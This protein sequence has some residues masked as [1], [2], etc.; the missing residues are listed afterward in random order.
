MPKQEWVARRSQLVT[1]YGVG[2]LMAVGSESVMI[3]GIDR[4]PGG[5][6]DLHEPRLERQLGVD[7]FRRPPASDD[8]GD[9]PVVRFPQMVSCPTPGCPVGI[10][11]HRQL[12]NKHDNHCPECRAEL[13]P[14]RFVVACRRGHLDE[15]PYQFWAHRT[16]R[17]PAVEHKLRIDARGASSA[18]RDIEITCSCGQSATM[19]GAF[20]RDALAGSSCR[21]RRPWL[22]DADEDGC[23]E[24]PRVLQRG[25][26][27]VWFP[28]LRS[29]LSIP[30]WSEGVFQLL[31]QHWPV[32]RA[33]PASAVLA[34]IESLYRPEELKH[35]GYTVQD[36]SDTVEER[37]K[38]EAA[39]DAGD[40]P[41]R[42]AEFQALERGRPETGP[43][44][45][46]VCEPSAG[47]TTFV[48][49]Y[50]ARVMLVKRL[51][52]VRVLE[53]F[54]RVLPPSP[55]DPPEF[56]AALSIEP[57]HWLPAI[58]VSGEGIFLQLDEERLRAWEA[59]GEVTARVKPLADR[60]R[61]RFI[62][63]G[64]QPDRDISPRFVL[65]HT[66]AHSLIGQWA[67]DS[68]YPAASL[69]ERLFVDEDHAG[70]LIYTAT[71]DSAGSLGGVIQQG[72]AERLEGS[73]REAVERAGWCSSDPLCAESEASGVD[74]LNLAA[75]HACV[76]LP[77]VS[78][79]EMNVL[80][81]RGLLIGL[82]Q[83]PGLAFFEPI[84]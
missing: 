75:C 67:L 2:S 61:E 29:A 7:G 30:P 82:P 12:T 63:R 20:N 54:T 50:F 56:H 1:T 4:W 66:L 49:Q 34:T 10:E 53:S 17:D 74:S 69:R 68:G 33:V 79:E 27:N 37:R 81:D 55:A 59:R 19:E 51:L 45:E 84:A 35:A 73:L 62:A 52:E 18:L 24:K 77:E 38:R 3:A 78:C 5:T 9:V 44:D 39:P 76:L 21:G 8:H 48:R 80:L 16:P 26:S 32:L 83:S 60:Y 11:Y 14:S 28:V 70:I 6:S 36:L 40:I 31:N 64:L 15:F 71:S 72:A 57:Q 13:I 25:A 41:I 47:I 58:D 65:A 42:S 46:F 23:D 43:N 22:R